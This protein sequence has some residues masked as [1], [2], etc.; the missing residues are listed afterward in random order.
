MSNNANNSLLGGKRYKLDNS[1]KEFAVAGKRGRVDPNVATMS[2]IVEQLHLYAD[3]LKNGN[4]SN[5]R[6]KT[7]E[8]SEIFKDVFEKPEN[9][10][11]V[12]NRALTILGKYREDRSY[13]PKM[14]WQSIS[15]NN[16]MIN[17][18]SART[19]REMFSV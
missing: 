19:F 1:E 2:L 3:F 6:Y 18:K 10:E 15:N 13:V 8:V 9:H 7:M 17:E 12:W 4:N 16:F 5:K 14:I 11:H